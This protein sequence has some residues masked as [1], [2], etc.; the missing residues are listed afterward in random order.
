MKLTIHFKTPDA[1]DNVLDYYRL[2]S[3]DESVINDWEQKLSTWINYNEY[4]SIEF[5]L[6]NMTAT[7]LKN[8]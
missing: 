3:V 1:V 2:K 5:D 8:K 7:V 6:D 4:I